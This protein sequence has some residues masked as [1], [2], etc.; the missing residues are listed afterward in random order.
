MKIIIIDDDALVCESL[1][2][3]AVHGAIKQGT[4]TIEVLAIGHDG[5]TA[6]DLYN[7]YQ[8]DIILLDIRMPELNGLEAGK[9][10]LEN[11]PE[12]KILYLTTFLDE[13]YIVQALRIGAKGYLMKSSV[14]N[15]LPALYAI[16]RGQRVFGDEIIEKLPPLLDQAAKNKTDYQAKNNIFSKLSE[17]EHTIVELIADGKNNREIAEALH[18][19]EGTIRNYLSTILEKLNLRD[20]TQLAITYYKQH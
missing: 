16:E 19:S 2:T 11:H 9:I 4:E 5:K 14:K 6:V 13:E 10:I 3:I 17:T 20:R 8:P 12:A 18:F 15:V 7:K 1:A